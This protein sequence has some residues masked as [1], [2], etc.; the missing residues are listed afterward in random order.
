MQRL[1][2]GL[3]E[4]WAGPRLSHLGIAGVQYVQPRSEETKVIWGNHQ[5]LVDALVRHDRPVS[6]LC[7]RVPIHESQ[8][9]YRERFASLSSK[10]VETEEYS[11]G[12]G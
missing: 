3:L 6:I 2:Q 11:V 8:K 1:I 9:S 12:T 10:K 4:D 5:V 7:G